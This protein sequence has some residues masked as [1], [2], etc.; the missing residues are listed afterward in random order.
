MTKSFE[1]TFPGVCAGDEELSE[2]YPHLNVT[3]VTVNAQHT[4]LKVYVEADRLIDKKDIRRIEKRI[5]EEVCSGSGMETKIIEKF[6]LSQQYNARNL[7]KAYRASIL[8]ELDQFDKCL[9][10][11]F[12]HADVTFGEDGLCHLVL[13]DTII[14]RRYEEQLCSILEKIFTDRCGV[15]FRMTVGYKEA[16]TAQK[17]RQFRAI[18]TMQKAEETLR[19]AGLLHKMQDAEIAETRVDGENAAAGNGGS[20]PAGEGGAAG[21]RTAQAASGSRTG[22]LSGKAGKGGQ[23]VRGRRGRGSAGSRND[24]ERNE[25]LVRS[26]NPDVL[27]G[28]DFEDLPIEMKSILGEM[29]DVT[30]RGQ[31]SEIET[32]DIHTK[33]GSDLTILIITLTDFTDTMRIKMFLD[34]QR[35][36]QLTDQLKTGMFIKV[37]GVTTIDKFD[38][39]LTI[40]KISM[41][42]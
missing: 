27:Y 8:Y 25:S 30:I 26:S 14:A 2:L 4:T 13:E 5:D 36:P 1:E 9:G 22:G 18:Q 29:G 7:M 11:L 35:A 24:S 38:S 19:E 39:D 41:A 21:G 42:S 15:D 12:R 40:G 3:R 10:N 31:V 34:T 32:R 6:R 20:V 16:S 33:R 23:G 37:R 28:R 17:T